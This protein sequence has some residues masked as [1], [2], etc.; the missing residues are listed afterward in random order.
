MAF[1]Q[2]WLFDNHACDSYILMLWKIISLSVIVAMLHQKMNYHTHKNKFSQTPECFWTQC[3]AN[4][5]V[6][7]TRIMMIKHDWNWNNSNWGS[8]LRSVVSLQQGHLTNTL[9]T[10]GLVSLASDK[11]FGERPKFYSPLVKPL[12]QDDQVPPKQTCQW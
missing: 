7:L 3:E 5:V 12:N 8:F 11:V 2:K 1:T 4:I 10:D 6:K 9:P